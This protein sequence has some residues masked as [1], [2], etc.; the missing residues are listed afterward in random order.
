MKVFGQ[1]IASAV[2]GALLWFLAVIHPWVFLQTGDP[3]LRERPES[4]EARHLVV[5]L[6]SARTL[7]AHLLDKEVVGYASEGSIDVRVGGP[8]QWRYYLA[9]MHLRLRSST[10]ISARPVS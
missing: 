1:P 3:E 10:T 4:N 6:S 9:R 7:G 2:L 8:L 5:V